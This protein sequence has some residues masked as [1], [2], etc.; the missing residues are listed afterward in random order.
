MAYWHVHPNNGWRQALATRKSVQRRGSARDFFRMEQSHP[1]HAV[2][3][4]PCFS[5]SSQMVFND[6]WLSERPR[7]NDLVYEAW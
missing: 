6:V 1:C 7:K 3:F 5:V 4:G 2:V